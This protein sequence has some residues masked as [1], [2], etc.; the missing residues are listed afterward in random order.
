MH[1]AVGGNF[2]LDS[3][4]AAALRVKLPLLAGWTAHRR[5]NAERYRQLFAAAPAIPA[6]LILPADE[7]GMIYNQFVVRAPA[8]TR[9]GLRAALTAGGIGTEIYYPAPLHL[10]PCFAELGFREGELPVTEVATR[11]VLALPIYPELSEAQQS[12]VVDRVAAFY[13]GAA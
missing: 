1:Q 9:D 12:W 7:P 10:Q 3:L 8:G 13:R 4:Q 5:A 6:E 2:R 11:E